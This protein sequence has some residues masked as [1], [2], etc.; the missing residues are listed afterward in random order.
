LNEQTQNQG[1]LLNWYIKCELQ[2]AHIIV[3]PSSW[4]WNDK[5]PSVEME[6]ELLI[7]FNCWQRTTDV[8]SIPRL[9][10]GKIT[11]VLIENKLFLI[12]QLKLL[13]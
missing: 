9:Y 2:E 12:L 8:Y 3:M 5:W 4:Y 11:E 7:G 10:P 13:R 6:K 1:R